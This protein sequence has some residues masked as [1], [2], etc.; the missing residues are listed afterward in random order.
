MAR[1]RPGIEHLL[2]RA[3]FG[4]SPEELESFEDMSTFQLLDYLLDY[5]AQPDDVDSKIGNSAYISVVARA[6]GFAPNTNIEDARQRWLFRMVHSRR[7]LQ[8]KMALFW[9]NHFATAYSKIS[10]NV[11]AAAATKMMALKEGQLPGPRGQLELFRDEGMGSFRDLLIAVAK[12]PAMLVWLDGRNN[13]R[14]RPQEN[15]GREVMELF[16]MGVGNYTEQDVYAAAKVFT[17]WNLRLVNR[18]NDND[19]YYE[20]V[21]IP[22]NHET[23]AKTFT[24]PIYAGGNNTIPARTAAQ[25]EQDGIDFITALAHHPATARRLARKLY[26]FFVSELDP[27]SDE[28]ITAAASVYLQ[29]GTRI[30]PLV[31]Y[32]LRSREFTTPSNYFTRY[33]WPV[34]FAIRSIKEVG[35]TGFSVDAVRGPLTAM[36]QTLFEPPD[37]AG[38]ELGEGWFSTGAM[39]A[40]MNY[41]A[42]LAANQQFNLARAAAD[43]KGSAESLTEYFLDRMSPSP[44]S[45][46]AHQDLLAYAQMGGAWTGSDAQVRAKSAGLTRLIVG[47]SEYQLV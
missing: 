9:H 46:E 35:W 12:D 23:A 16:T 39:V 43:A 7:P 47:S 30:A 41:A 22:G 2:R 25:G 27:P 11:P 17:G 40:R 34:E 10:G 32:L 19:T 13:T 44:F 36:G 14:Q 37:V 24:F 38:W 1:S 42:T 4:A 3:G 8:E 28:T 29:N 20:Y 5:E 21:Y 45:N 31:A 33:S 6:G 15:F 18:G 26:A